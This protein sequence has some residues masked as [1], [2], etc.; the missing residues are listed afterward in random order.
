MEYTQGEM[1]ENAIRVLN[2]A[3]EADYDAM[4]DFLHQFVKV[5]EILADHPTIQVGVTNGGEFYMRPLGLINGLFA[6]DGQQYGF[7][8]YLLDKDTG[9]ILGFDTTKPPEKEE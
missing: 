1:V 7:I 3:L 8:C 2:E 4:A 5:N 9:R 6:V